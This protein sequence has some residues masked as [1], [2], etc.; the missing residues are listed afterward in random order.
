MAVEVQYSSNP[1]KYLRDETFNT[2]N[3]IFQSL[4]L[5]LQS[6]RTPTRLRRSELITQRWKASRLEDFAFWKLSSCGVS[7]RTCGKH[8]WR[9]SQQLSWARGFP[10]PDRLASKQNRSQ[11]AQRG[12]Q[13]SERVYTKRNESDIKLLSGAG[14]STHIVKTSQFVHQPVELEQVEVPVAQNRPLVNGSPWRGEAEGIGGCGKKSS[15]TCLSA[16]EN[17]DFSF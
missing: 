5:L 14:S 2:S 6:V 1:Y 4:I 13:N 8:I 11:S 12:R 16:G 17:Y 3:K 7:V 9:C 15:T 10:N